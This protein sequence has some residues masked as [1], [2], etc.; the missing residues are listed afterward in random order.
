MAMELNC[1]KKKK[2]KKGDCK[3]VDSSDFLEST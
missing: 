3:I 1:Y 2:K